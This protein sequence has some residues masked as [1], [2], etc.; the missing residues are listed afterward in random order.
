[1]A[2]RTNETS[3]CFCKMKFYR[4][5]SKSIHLHIVYNSFLTTMANLSGSDRDY[6]AH[7]LKILT[8]W[9]FT[10]KFT[11]SCI[12]GLNSLTPS[13]VFLSQFCKPLADFGLGIVRIDL[14]PGPRRDWSK[15]R[16]LFCLW[17]AVCKSY[18][19]ILEI[20]STALP[21]EKK[22]TLSWNKWQKKWGSLLCCRYNLHTGQGG[23][24]LAE[25][26]IKQRPTVR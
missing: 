2:H 24:K 14:H 6:M 8:T 18:L 11:N 20:Y 23:G 3:S 26:L 21:T 22:M 17:S 12:N 1:M 4:N 15:I 10:E 19:G 9:P 5:T 7:K 13:S 25:T 16:W